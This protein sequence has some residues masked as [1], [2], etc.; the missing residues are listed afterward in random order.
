MM[1]GKR[2]GTGKVNGA[3]PLREISRGFGADGD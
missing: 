1:T 2:A 3:P